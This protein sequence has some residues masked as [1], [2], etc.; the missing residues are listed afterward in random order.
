MRK[1]VF[2]CFLALLLVLPSSLAI[3]LGAG[4]ADIRFADVLRGGYAE[5]AI[6]VSNPDNF[7]LRV[8]MTVNGAVK[9]WLASP[10]GN[11]FN[12]PP[13]SRLE[14]KLIVKPPLDAALGDY[15]GSIT[16][17]GEPA[18]VTLAATGT[19]LQPGVQLNLFVT[20]TGE[21][22]L[23]FAVDSVA[24]TD[25]EEGL[26]IKVTM[27]GRNTGNV[28]IAPR[29]VVEILDRD[30]TEVVYKI[31]KTFDDFCPPH[32]ILD[33]SISPRRTFP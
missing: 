4:P 9:T 27:N 3:G 30:R 32:P 12:I 13:N 17:I 26:P 1:F 8:N 22:K 2:F 6:I 31:E 19:Y 20:L 33:N 25:T 7:S 28:R 5:Q 29:I 16:L 21:Q 18:N 14:L 15:S 23:G 10:V 24:I 11:M